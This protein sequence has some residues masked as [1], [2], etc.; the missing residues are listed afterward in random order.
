VVGGFLFVPYELIGKQLLETKADGSF[1]QIT[2]L[3]E[4]TDGRLVL[5]HRSKNAE[6]M[7]L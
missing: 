1:W 5:R 7:S 2:A 6:D 3:C 4:F